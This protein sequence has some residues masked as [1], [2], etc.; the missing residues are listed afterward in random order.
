MEFNGGLSPDPNQAAS[1]VVCEMKG[2]LLSRMADPLNIP[3]GKL[4]AG[5][6]QQYIGNPHPELQP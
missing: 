4:L 2:V 6:A 3:D 5:P 1:Q